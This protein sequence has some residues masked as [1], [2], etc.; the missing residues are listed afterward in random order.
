MDK[1]RFLVKSEARDLGEQ[2]PLGPYH[3]VKGEA[4][5]GASRAEGQQWPTLHLADCCEEQAG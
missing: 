5:L 4:T 2:T 1:P 3:H